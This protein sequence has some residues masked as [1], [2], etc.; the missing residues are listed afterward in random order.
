MNKTLPHSRLPKLPN[1]AAYVLAG[2]VPRVPARKRHEAWQLGRH[3]A[4]EVQSVQ[5]SPFASTRGV[6]A[7][8]WF[9]GTRAYDQLELLASPHKSPRHL[10]LGRP[11]ILPTYLLYLLDDVRSLPLPPNQLDPQFST[12]GM[13]HQPVARALDRGSE[14]RAGSSTRRVRDGWQSPVC[15][16]SQD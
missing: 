12:G 5:L 4:T 11:P 1:K 6:R 9:P 15:A 3:K 2:D 13:G 10:H 8:P 16:E 7:N 14:P